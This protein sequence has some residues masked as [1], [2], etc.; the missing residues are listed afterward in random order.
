MRRVVV[1]MTGHHH[2]QYFLSPDSS[3]HSRSWIMSIE[4][5]EDWLV[6]RKRKVVIKRVF[7]LENKKAQPIPVVFCVLV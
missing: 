5:V 4:P 3:V 2:V 1:D 7:F 6:D